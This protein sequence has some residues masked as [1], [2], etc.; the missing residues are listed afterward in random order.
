MEPRS[1]KMEAL[2]GVIVLGV[3]ALFTWLSFQIGSGAPRGAVRYHLLFDSALG[4]NE[5]NTVAVAGVKIGVVDAIGI[6]GRMAKVTVA[7]DPGVEIFE[8]ARAA[9]RA[10]S[11][12][13]EK[14][15]DIDPGSEPAQRLAPDSTLSTNIPTVEIDQVLRASATLIA[16]LNAMVPPLENAVTRIDGM[17]RDTDGEMVADEFGKV[18]ADTSK[19]IQ[20]TSSLVTESS[21]DLQALLRLAR[22]R[23]PDIVN[24]LDTTTKKLDAVLAGLD[25]ERI[26]NATERVAPTMEN[27]DV[28]VQDLRLAMKEVKDASKRID[29]LLLK[30]EE[31]LER[32]E[33]ITERNI[34]EFLQVQGVRVQFIPDASVRRRLQQLKN[35]PESAPLP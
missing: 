2:L 32:T 3:L 15:I 34:R 17:L 9:V 11:L 27:I 14:Y 18:L 25:A 24:R 16:S 20:E 28:A 6:D 13:G 7:V 10:K 35:T 26:Q 29:G 4:L 5:D 22:E 21:D 30:T 31:A 1:Y 33:W 12:L 19:L 23:A 8:N